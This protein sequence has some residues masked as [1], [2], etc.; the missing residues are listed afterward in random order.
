MCAKFQVYAMT[1]LGWASVAD[2]QINII[3][4]IPVNKGSNLWNQWLAVTDKLSGGQ[5]RVESPPSWLMMSVV[6]IKKNSAA[7]EN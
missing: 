3:I 1:G 4:I 2:R 6:V 5:Y 7:T